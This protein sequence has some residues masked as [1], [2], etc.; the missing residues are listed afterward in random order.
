MIDVGINRIKG[1]DGKTR[2]VGDVAPEVADIA[3]ALSPV[4]GGVG[5]LTTTICESTV[6]AAELAVISHRA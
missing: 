1:A 3:G 6:A 2:T 5:S 4:P